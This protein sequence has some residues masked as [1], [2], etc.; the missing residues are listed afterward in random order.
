MAADHE[1]QPTAEDQHVII[2]FHYDVI[3]CVKVI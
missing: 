1:E 2:A 3:K